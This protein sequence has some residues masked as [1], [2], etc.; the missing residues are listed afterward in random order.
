MKVLIT[1]INGFIG[2]NVASKFREH[3]YEVIGIDHKDESNAFRTYIADLIKDDLVGILNK[4]RPDIFI[5]CAGLASVPYSI[6]SPE[7]DFMVNTAVVHRMLFAI[8]QSGLN[9]RRFIFLSSAAVYGQ[10]IRLP[11]S[12]INE[13]SPLSPYALHKKM[14]EDIC[15]YFVRNHGSI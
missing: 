2:K 11:I 9:D 5:H 8:Y 6:E 3:G 12:E 15:L 4:E 7:K 14:A 1:G 10:P 13:C